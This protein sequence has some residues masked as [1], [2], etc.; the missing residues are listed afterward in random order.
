[1]QWPCLVREPIVA[2]LCSRTTCVWQI[3]LPQKLR[4]Q[5]RWRQALALHKRMLMGA[6]I[7]PCQRGVRQ[8]RRI[9]MRRN[10]SHF[11]EVIAS[12]EGFETDHELGSD[13]AWPELRAASRGHAN[14]QD[15]GLW[16]LA[17]SS[18]QLTRWRPVLVKPRP[19]TEPRSTDRPSPDWPDAA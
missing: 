15:L 13:V 4:H 9:D 17:E 16:H 11:L 12:S 14:A 19:R 3:V 2:P 8:G 1:V 7:G 5:L 10:Q 18:E 6:N